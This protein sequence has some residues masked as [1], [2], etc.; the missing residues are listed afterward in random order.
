[1]TERAKL[2]GSKL[3]VWSEV[4]SGTEVELSIPA[5]RAYETSTPRRR[6]WLAER[7]LGKETKLKS[8]IRF[9][10][11]GRYRTA[12]DRVDALHCLSQA[13][14]PSSVR[15]LEAEDG[16]G[17]TLRP[18]CPRKSSSPTPLHCLKWL[19][20]P[21]GRSSAFYRVHQDSSGRRGWSR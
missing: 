12:E 15:P 6:S 18:S 1:M 21:T 10:A 20:F 19:S 3:T 8:W 11:D 14:L 5:S 2:M 9:C 13:S 17:Y 16:R 4:E 7:L